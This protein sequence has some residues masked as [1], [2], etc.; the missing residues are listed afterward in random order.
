ME[1]CSLLNII[2]PTGY[3]FSLSSVT[4]DDKK[5]TKHL[6]LFA[7]V[8]YWRSVLL[9]SSEQHIRYLAVRQLTTISL[10]RQRVDEQARCPIMWAKRGAHS[11]ALM[12]VFAQI[13]R[14]PGGLSNFY[15]GALR[16]F[17]GTHTGMSIAEATE[18]MLVI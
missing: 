6:V 17:H 16:S 18:E 1:L 8:V 12:C 13:N 4:R 9:C 7:R 14:S 2:T 3:P 11:S 15:N 10:E 5:Q